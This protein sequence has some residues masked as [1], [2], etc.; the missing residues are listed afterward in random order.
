MAK[1]AGI[2][3]IISKLITQADRQADV[4]RCRQQPIKLQTVGLRLAA[5]VLVEREWTVNKRQFMIVDVTQTP[6][7]AEKP[8][9][10]QF[11]VPRQ[12][13]RLQCR[14]FDAEARLAGGGVRRGI[15]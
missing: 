15:D 13:R 6:E 12:R 8:S 4:V 9:C 2:I 14:L 7:L 1:R 5:H 3:W 11:E 10:F